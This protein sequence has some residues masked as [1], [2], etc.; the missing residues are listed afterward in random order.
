[1]GIALMSAYVV[2]VNR[3]VWHPLSRLA[4]SRYRLS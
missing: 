1:V 3:M 2:G 4:E